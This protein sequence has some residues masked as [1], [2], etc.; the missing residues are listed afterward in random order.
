[1]TQRTPAPQGS[2][3][4]HHGL[5]ASLS[6]GVWSAG[7]HAGAL[8]G[9]PSGM[10]GCGRVSQSC[11]AWKGKEGRKL[12]SDHSPIHT[13]RG[14]GSGAD[15]LML[16]KYLQSPTLCR[17]HS[18]K[19]LY[20]LKCWETVIN[21]MTCM[22]VSNKK[23]VSFLG[24]ESSVISAT[25]ILRFPNIQQNGIGGICFFFFFLLWL[26][27]HTLSLPAFQSASCF[28]VL[29]LLYHDVTAEENSRIKTA[30]LLRLGI[31][32]V[33]SKLFAGTGPCLH[34]CRNGFTSEGIIQNTFVGD[35]FS[36][37][38]NTCIH[39][40]QPQELAR[41]FCKQ[42]CDKHHIC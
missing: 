30:H 5:H 21:Q 6:M 7:L 34:M 4:Q 27:I 42:L 28:L 9:S 32:R 10:N 14:W 3:P 11:H 2:P 23:P 12:C 1:M 37:H 31:C 15:T 18:S 8:L 29:F 20:Y 39:I 35:L 16:S 19:I 36:F 26:L 40:V 33:P 38:P 13:S 41:Q 25:G 17:L 22:H 24:F